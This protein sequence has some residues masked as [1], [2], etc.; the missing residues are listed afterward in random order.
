MTPPD[1]QAVFRLA[2]FADY[3]E[4]NGAVLLIAPRIAANARHA[5]RFYEQR[6]CMVR[7]TG[8]DFLG[9]AMQPISLPRPVTVGKVDRCTKSSAGWD[10]ILLFVPTP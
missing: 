2:E 9:I 3:V 4:K 6:L 8:V 1:E 7:W 5:R 10:S